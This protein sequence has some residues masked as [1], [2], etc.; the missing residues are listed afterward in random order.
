M[1]TPTIKLF[2]IAALV[3]STGLAL[4][5][6]ADPM[7][8]ID[9]RAGYSAARIDAAFN[10]VA[11]IPLTDP[12]AIPMADKGDLL[13]IGCAGPFRPDVA[14]ECLDTAYELASD[15]PS[16]V[17]ET[18]VGDATSML[19]RM[20]GFTVADMPDPMLDIE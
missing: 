10:M 14:A 20:M 11:E 4:A 7:P 16:I 15:D 18:R 9:D 5:A 13:P 19:M 12:V 1:T 2:A 8:A 3:V 6:E 17:V